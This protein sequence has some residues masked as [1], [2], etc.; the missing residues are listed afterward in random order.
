MLNL[1]DKTKNLK[2]LYVEDSPEVRQSTLLLLKEFFDNIITASN[3]KEGLELYEKGKPDLII[4]DINMPEMSG[5]EM[6]KELR[7]KDKDI[8]IIITS[9]HSELE[10]LL[11]SIK[12]G[13]DGYILKPVDLNQF[14]NT[15]SKVVEKVVLKEEFDKTLN[16]LKQYQ[17]AMDELFI[18]SKT[19][20][21]GTITYVNKKFEDVSKY[22]KEE[23]L[24]KSHNIIR[25]PDNPSQ[26]FRNIWE[27][28]KDKKQ[29]WK[30][31]IKNKAKNGITYY[32]NTVIMPILDEKGQVKEFISIGSNITEIINPKKKLIDFL[33]KKRTY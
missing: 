27:T 20:E 23:L 31:I 21:K 6:I 33:K 28:I 32:V 2:V 9:A 25:H 8:P 17:M 3:G 22:S 12:L 14:I 5:I 10:F 7:K 4:T 24:G 16:L 1:I 15:I 19:D 18:V 29:I 13:V 30:G 11:E 26:F